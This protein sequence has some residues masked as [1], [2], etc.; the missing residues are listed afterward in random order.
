MEKYKKPVLA[1]HSDDP[2]HWDEGPEVK[3]SLPWPHDPGL[4]YCCGGP[5]APIVS[6]GP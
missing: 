6:K 4:G 2:A 3:Q 5:T 1:L